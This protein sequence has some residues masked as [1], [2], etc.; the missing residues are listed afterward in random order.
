MLHT[1][2]VDDGEDRVET[3]DGVP[4]EWLR[5]GPIV[6]RNEM[7]KPRARRAIAI[8]IAPHVYGTGVRAIEEMANVR[9]R[10]TAEELAIA[11][12][13]RLEN[14]IRVG[15][16]DDGKIGTAGPRGER[17]TGSV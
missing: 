5:L 15:G 7:A 14:S 11:L 10:C 3:E 1:I 6:A 16:H 8:D 12:V 9:R 17:R 2:A 4:F 13:P